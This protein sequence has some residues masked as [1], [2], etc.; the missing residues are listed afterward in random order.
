[1]CNIRLVFYSVSFLTMTSHQLFVAL[2]CGAVPDILVPVSSVMKACFA[3]DRDVCGY[4]HQVHGCDFLGD[5]LFPI[6]YPRSVSWHRIL[7]L[8]SGFKSQEFQFPFWVCLR[9]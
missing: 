1:M 8:V 9:P 4:C 3:T 6:L 2:L 7:E 5:V